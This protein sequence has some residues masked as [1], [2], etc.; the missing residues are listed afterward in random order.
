MNEK[1]EDAEH[2]GRGE[3]LA[4]SN[5]VKGEEWV[6]RGLFGDFGSGCFVHDGLTDELRGSGC[7]VTRIVSVDKRE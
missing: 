6:K 4:G 5:Q 3:E 7:S 2:D 1:G